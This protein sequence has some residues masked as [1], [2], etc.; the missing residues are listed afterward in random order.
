MPIK[1]N[2]GV[3][4]FRACVAMVWLAAQAIVGAPETRV[5]AIGDVHGAYDEF[6]SILQ[7]TQLIDGNAQWIGG[8]SM[9]VQVGDVMD[10]G[11]KARASLDL[12]MQLERQAPKQNGRVIALLGNHEAMNMMGDLRY[13]NVEEYQE[14]AT[15]QSEK[16]R[17]QAYQDYRDYLKARGRRRGQAPPPDD[18]ASRQK[19]MAD[20]PPGF[21]EHRDAYSPQGLYGRWLRK[22]DAV[23]QLDDVIFLHGGLDPELRFRNLQ[24]LN[25]RVR[26]ELATY[27]SLWH[28]LSDKQIIWRYMRQEEAFREVVE[29][30][31]AGQSGGL[32]GDTQAA[33]QMR[34]FLELQQ[35]IVIYKNGPLWYRGYFED[36][37]EALKG[38]L[39]KM[40]ERLKARHVVVG[41]TVPESRR[42]TPVLDSRVFQID[43]GMLRAVYQ[44]H[45]GAL[46]IQNGRF[47]ASYADGEQKVLLAP[48]SARAV[49]PNQPAEGHEPR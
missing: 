11:P 39:D 40:L 20:H 15:D 7:R 33:E 14:F 24:E 25:D 48:D 34:K 45:P 26:A 6:V 35:G 30:L 23:A 41:H 21:F 18:E 42:I 47:T 4:L 31:K 37:A 10:R 3:Y 43:A 1:S 2:T 49:L 9:L 5:V 27:D 36:H 19:W 22:H 38:P 44:G 17:E 13:V 28:S 32:G 46:E 16:V 8:S 12:L 29:V